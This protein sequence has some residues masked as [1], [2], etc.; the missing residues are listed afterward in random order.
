MTIID[1]RARR[2]CAALLACAGALSAPIA[3]AQSRTAGWWFQ[4]GAFRPSVD[5]TLRV[6]DAGGA[7]GTQF[8]AENALGLPRRKT[9][10][11]G[12]I[13]VRLGDRWRLEV[14]HFAL[15]RSVRQFALTESVVI[16]DTTFPVSARV[17]TDFDSKIT[18]V[19]GGVSF[20]KTDTA[21]VG[22]VIGAHVTNFEFGVSGTFSAGG[23]APATF[24]REARDVTVPL[25]TVG[26][27]G[28]VAL[29]PGLSLNGRA[30][31]FSLSH[32]DIDGRLLNLQANLTWHF[33]P[34]FGIGA[35]YRLTDYRIESGRGEDFRG[36]ME[37]EFRGPLVFI[38]ARF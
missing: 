33:T 8:D 10:A 20:V 27:F 1:S 3:Q 34:N 14:E 4:L 13:G 36:R 22:L 17:D 19:S 16:D 12:L 26:L 38:D 2:G 5:S 24:R 25:P 18:R 11:S 37:Y 15:N 32:R 9:L 28:S 6:D 21:E 30:D 7:N 35:G 31:A 23:G 29:A